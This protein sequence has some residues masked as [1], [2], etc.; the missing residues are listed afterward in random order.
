[1]SQYC[2]GEY[3]NYAANGVC[4][5][6]D[7]GAPDFEPSAKDPYY[8]LKPIG[9]RATTVFVPMGNELL[10][11][12]MRKLLTKEEIDSLLG[13]VKDGSVEWINDRKKRAELFE[14]IIKRNGILDI[15]RLV[16]CL[17][18]KREELAGKIGNKRLTFSDQD[19]LERA[20]RLIEDEFSFVLGI[21]KAEV[22][23]YI[24]RRIDA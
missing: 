10:L 20:E 4:L 24:K 16:G 8:I 6:A 5:V 12:R 15:L 3:V 13:A 22:A 21:P 18:I 9:D 19:V 23:E 2:K 7:I 1:M 11:S 14:G 17:Y